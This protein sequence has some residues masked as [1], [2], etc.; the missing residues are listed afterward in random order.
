MFYTIHV[1]HG[2]QGNQ[3]TKK[4]QEGKDDEK[5]KFAKKLKKEQPVCKDVK[6]QGMRRVR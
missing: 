1:N 5:E 4:K 6:I 3:I 2:P